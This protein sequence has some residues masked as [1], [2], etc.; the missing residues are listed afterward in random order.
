MSDPTVDWQAWRDDIDSRL[1]ALDAKKQDRGDYLQRRRSQRL[2]QESD[3]AAT[4]ASESS[5]RLITSSDP[6]RVASNPC[7]PRS[8]TA[9]K[10]VSAP[11][12]PG[13]FSGLSLG[14]TAGRRTRTERPR[15]AR[16]DHR[17]RP[18]GS[19]HQT[20][21]LANLPTLNSQPSTLNHS[22][23]PSTRHRRRNRRCPNLITCPS[24]AT[25][26]A[27]AHQWAR[28]QVARKYPGAT[29]VLTHARIA[30]QT[31]TGRNVKRRDA[32]LSRH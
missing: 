16:R 28:E 22:P 29:E 23:S 13:L 4:V 8:S 1:A 21:R 26:F 12:S 7:E 11:C 2:C 19:T 15:R 17:R 20:P 25:D 6:P 10:N 5:K 30:D 3:V 27:R 32:R 18:R 24:S 31:A 14:K 9:S